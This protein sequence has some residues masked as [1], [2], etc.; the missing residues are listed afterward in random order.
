MIIG[1]NGPDGFANF[2]DGI[3]QWWKTQG[4]ALAL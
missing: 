2:A 1:G 3:E 4:F